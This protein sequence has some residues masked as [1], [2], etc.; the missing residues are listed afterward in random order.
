MIDNEYKKI[1]DSMITEKS[2]SIIIKYS[3]YNQNYKYIP[4][5]HPCNNYALDNLYNL[6]IDNIIFYAF[7]ENEILNLQ[8]STEVLNDLRSAAKYSFYERLP[9]RLNANTDGTIGEVLLD[10][11]IQVFEPFSQKLIARAK[12]TEMSKK[13]EITGYDA[14]YFTKTNDE[15]PMWLGQAKAGRETYCKNDIKKDLNKKFTSEYF[16]NTAF[17]IADKSD[18]SDL[19]ELLNKINKICFEAQQKEF[20]KEKKIANLYQLLQQNNIHIK[21]PCL[22]AYTKDIYNDEDAISDQIDIIKK[23][24]SKYYETETFSINIGLPYEIIFYI[25]PIQNVS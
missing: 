11:I 18:S 3:S 20:T 17:Y 21:I 9:K 14:L 22:L 7:S 23:S 1:Y 19:T 25:F 6:I 5:T 13:T 2:K 16:S 8:K 12:H 4:F 24:M 10:L 15:I